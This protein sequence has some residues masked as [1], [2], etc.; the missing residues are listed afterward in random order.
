MKVSIHDLISTIPEGKK[1][2]YVGRTYFSALKK[3]YENYQDSFDVEVDDLVVESFSTIIQNNQVLQ[4]LRLFS[5]DKLNTIAETDCT[6]LSY[7]DIKNLLIDYYSFEYELDIIEPHVLASES[8]CEIGLHDYQ[9]RIRRKV[10]NLIFNNQKR[11]LIHMP[12]GSGKTRTAGEIIIDFIRYSASQALFNEKIKIIWIAQSSELCVQAYQTLK[13]LIDKKSTT[14]F[15]FVHFYGN[16]DISDSV[17]DEPAIIIA[18]I[19]KLLLNYQ[20][21]I[22]SAIKNTNYLVVVDE[23][24]RSVAKEWVKALNYFVSDNNTYL[25]GL[26]ATPGLGSGD[27]NTYSL[28]TYYHGNKISL[29]DNNYT[30]IQQP[31]NY[32]VNRGFLANIKRITIESSF[33]PDTDVLKDDFDNFVFTTQTLKQLSVNPARNASIINIIRESFKNGEKVLVFTCGIEHNHILKRILYENGIASETV[34]ASSKNRNSVIERFKSKDLNVLLN[35]GVLTTGFD[36]PKTNVCIIARPIASIVMYS[37][38]V[39]RILRGPKNHGNKENVL[40]T[41]KDNFKHGDYDNMFNSFNQ[42]YN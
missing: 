3:Y 29:T 12:T 41:I 6:A 25:L 31:I 15:S 23:A 27:D 5:L 28:S 38:M 20:K 7:T 36:A 16:N 33:I 14:N 10:I 40:Y 39:G 32:L 4:D 1:I 22:W 9:E 26:T 8:T 35:F 37:Q 11:F 19:Q 13:W 21:P 42:Y 34:E 17:V 30:E 2:G 18:S 24:H